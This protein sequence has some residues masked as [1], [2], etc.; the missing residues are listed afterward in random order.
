[1]HFLKNKIFAIAIVAF[2]AA[3]LTATTVPIASAHDPP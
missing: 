1:M 3:S 2:L